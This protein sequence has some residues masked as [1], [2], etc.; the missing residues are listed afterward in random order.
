MSNQNNI[1]KITLNYYKGIVDE[2]ELEMYKLK[3][4]EIDIKLIEIVKIASQ[5]D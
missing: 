1:S 4:S 5:Y 3:L 2:D